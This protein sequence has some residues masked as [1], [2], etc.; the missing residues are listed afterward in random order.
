MKRRPHL[1]GS[2][3][4]HLSPFAPKAPRLNVT[5]MARFTLIATFLL[6]G[7]ACDGG[8]GQPSAE[9][10]AKR[11]VEVEERSAEVGRL[12]ARVASLNACAPVVE[13]AI[14]EE[15]ILDAA[16][17]QALVSPEGGQLSR[18]YYSLLG[19]KLKFLDRIESDVEACTVIR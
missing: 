16:I 14:R 19:D 9:S 7:L 1:R 3:R 15:R 17:L 8:L 10:V 18:K 5:T 13:T 11:E 2:A 6:C 12:A 4:P